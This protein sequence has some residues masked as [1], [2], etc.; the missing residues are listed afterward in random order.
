MKYKKLL[1]MLESRIYYKSIYWR[2]QVKMSDNE[3]YS[4]NEEDS[5][6]A[7]QLI[8]EEVQLSEEE[9]PIKM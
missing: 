2:S 4:E 7:H 9:G 1:I 5:A 3:N 8:F 6:I